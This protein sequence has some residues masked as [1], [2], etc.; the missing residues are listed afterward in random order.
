M[1]LLNEKIN[2]SHADFMALNQTP[3]TT[4]ALYSNGV[5]TYQG[6]W[7]CDAVFKYTLAFEPG[8]V[9]EKAH[10]HFCFPIAVKNNP[11][12]TYCILP[13]RI[14]CEDFR[15]QMEQLLLLLK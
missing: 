15:N 11:T 1:N 9:L 10:E 4:W 8:V 5:I 2:Q 7:T 6:K 13:S 14:I 12:L 3:A